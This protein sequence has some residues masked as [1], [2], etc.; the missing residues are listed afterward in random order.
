MHLKKITYVDSLL[1]PD[2][3]SDHSGTVEVKQRDEVEDCVLEA[4][5]A[6]AL[7]VL[8]CCVAWDE[9]RDKTCKAK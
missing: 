8:S 2:L 7:G 3:A 6:N 5:L 9:P 1:V 4:I